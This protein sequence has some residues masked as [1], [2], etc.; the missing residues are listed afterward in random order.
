M[1]ENDRSLAELVEEYRRTKKSANLVRG[2]IPLMIIGVF[3]VFV[4]IVYGKIQ[5]FDAETFQDRLGDR[6]VKLAPKVSD[7]LMKVGAEVVPAYSAELEKQLDGSLARM[8]AVI[9]REVTLL[10]GNLSKHLTAQLADFTKGIAVSHRELVL[11]E[12]PQYKDDPAQVYAIT[13]A[14]DGAFEK[15][16]FDQINSTFKRHVEALASI[17]ETAQL[18]RKDAV[19]GGTKRVSGQDV[20][21]IWLELINEKFD[22]DPDDKPKPK[23]RAKRNKA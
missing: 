2:L 6:A 1:S 7:A 12:F 3:V 16:F 5:G 17:Q 14:V 11:K 4:L 10:E 18:L 15:W 23:K 8:G 9:D 13:S 22:T 21:G 19:K 20:L